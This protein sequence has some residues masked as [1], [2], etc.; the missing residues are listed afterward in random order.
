MPQEL[1]TPLAGARPGGRG[2]R[3]AR[4]RRRHV[5]DGLC[6]VARNAGPRT[7]RRRNEILLVS[8]AAAVRIALL[9]VAALVRCCTDPDPECIT[10]LHRLL[11]SGCDSPLY[12]P[13]VPAGQLGATLERA[14]TTL[15][16]NKSFP[17]SAPSRLPS[18][19][20]PRRSS[21]PAPS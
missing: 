4:R 18:S 15:A 17:D 21:P 9:Q 8:R 19:E 5:A 12:N 7:R 14:R 13:D 16:T 1:T 10:E 20:H 6:Y 3:A 11:T 2:A